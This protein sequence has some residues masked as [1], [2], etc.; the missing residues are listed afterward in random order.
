MKEQLEEQYYISPSLLKNIFILK[1]RVIIF[2][3]SI[4]ELKTKHKNLEE[5]Q[6]MEH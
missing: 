5:I 4:K 1:E 3:D 6:E 2:I